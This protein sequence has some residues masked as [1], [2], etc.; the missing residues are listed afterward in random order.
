MASLNQFSEQLRRGSLTELPEHLL[1]SVLC[2]I[3]SFW[4]K[5]Q[6]KNTNHHLNRL[7][8]EHFK[9]LKVVDLRNPFQDKKA[10]MAAISTNWFSCS[11][12]EVKVEPKYYKHVRKQL[13]ASH[14]QL[15]PDIG[16]IVLKED[17]VE[18][19]DDADQLDADNETIE[20]IKRRAG[21]FYPLLSSKI[22][23]TNS[24]EIRYCVIG[25]QRKVDFASILFNLLQNFLARVENRARCLEDFSAVEILT[26]HGICDSISPDI[27]MDMT[28]YFVGL[29]RLVL[30]I[31]SFSAM[32]DKVQALIEHSSQ[33][34][35]EVDFKISD[36]HLFS[37]GSLEI[38]SAALE[39]LAPQISYWKIP[40]NVSNLN[41]S[42]FRYIKRLHIDKCDDEKVRKLSPLLSSVEHLTLSD[43]KGPFLNYIF[44]MIQRNGHGWKYFKMTMAMNINEKARPP[45]TDME[46]FC[47]A[48]GTGCP[49]L[50][51]LHFEL[52]DSPP[53]KF[54]HFKNLLIKIGN[55]LKALGVNC[56]V[57]NDDIL[58][59]IACNCENL[60]Y[61]NLVLEAENCADIKTVHDKLKLHNLKLLN[62]EFV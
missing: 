62:V 43:V 61:L 7:V 41:V 39:A 19:A 20:Q 60:E 29:K 5:L 30:D 53:L 25:R 57:V 33:S 24:G 38:T 8:Q 52:P 27:I 54:K 44:S 59:V 16:K 14:P 10:K 9:K 58:E 26:I 31:E 3:P 37:A 34:K 35:Y 56:Y 18:V 49:Q 50:E 36:Q 51:R 40:L 48:I 28:K 22:K 42:P 11:L 6:I 47:N 21:Y 12:T 17:A 15:F 4:L 1:D 55:R 23:K 2:F 45:A 13:E 32:S 46:R